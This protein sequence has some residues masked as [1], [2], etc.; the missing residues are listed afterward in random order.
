MDGQA[1]SGV[2]KMT[3]M[4]TKGGTYLVLGCPAPATVWSPDTQSTAFPS[5][6]RANGFHRIWFGFGCWGQAGRI[7]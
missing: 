3:Y 2:E 1:V 4:M 7:R 5:A 6:G